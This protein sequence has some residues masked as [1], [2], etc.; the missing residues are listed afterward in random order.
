[1]ISS[2]RF[3]PSKEDP[4][5]GYCPRQGQNHIQNSDVFMFSS[6]TCSAAHSPQVSRH[7]WIRC[8]SFRFFFYLLKFFLVVLFPPFFFLRNLSGWRLY[9]TPFLITFGGRALSNVSMCCRCS[10]LNE[11]VGELTKIK[12]NAAIWLGFVCIKS[13]GFHGRFLGMSVTFSN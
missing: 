12:W 8:I 3:L 4:G 7:L 11:C 13:H 10:W 2:D 9:L 5:T 1:M 6:A